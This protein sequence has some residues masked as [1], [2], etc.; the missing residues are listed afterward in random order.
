[1]RRFFSSWFP[2]LVYLALIF[3]FSSYS[4]PATPLTKGSATYLLH[5]MEFFV[6]AVLVLRAV[7]PYRNPFLFAILFAVLFGILDEIHQLFVPGRTFS[8]YDMFFDAVGACFVLIFKNKRL[9]S[10][11]SGEE[12]SML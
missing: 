9:G 4:L 2:L 8:Y 11:I 5:A 7:Y 10:R 12:K 1:M 3:L 6:L